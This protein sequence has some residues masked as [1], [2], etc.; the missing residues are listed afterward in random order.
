[1]YRLSSAV[2]LLSSSY[3][4]SFFVLLVIRIPSLDYAIGTVFLFAYYIPAGF[5]PPVGIRVGPVGAG[6]SVTEADRQ[7]FRKH[8]RVRNVKLV[9]NFLFNL[10][11]QQVVLGRC[12]ELFSNR[13]IELIGS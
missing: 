12:K 3:S 5:L 7:S 11:G 4:R 8:S 10:F 6:H 13:R 9:H 2:L 1:M